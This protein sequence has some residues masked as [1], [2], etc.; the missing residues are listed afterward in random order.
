[1]VYP[2]RTI[3][4]V[5]HL[6]LHQLMT[7]V[8]RC[9]AATA[10]RRARAVAAG[11]GVFGGGK[12]GG[13]GGHAVWY[14]FDVQALRPLQPGKA[15]KQPVF[16]KNHKTRWVDAKNAHA[17][18]AAISRILSKLIF[19]SCACCLDRFV[20]PCAAESNYGW[21]GRHGRDCTFAP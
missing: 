4:C 8:A 17:P 1:M 6:N 7:S 20:A 14:P 19:A 2:V 15:D 5:K 12:A 9:S 21:Y 16:V 11:E 18:R 13:A 3:H 10:G